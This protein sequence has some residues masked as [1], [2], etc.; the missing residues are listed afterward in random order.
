MS[1]RNTCLA[2][3]FALLV[4]ATMPLLARQ[5]AATAGT[6]TTVV[7]TLEPRRESTI[8]PISQGDLTVVEAGQTRPVTG[9]ESLVNAPTQMLI[10]IDDSARSSFNSLIPQVKQFIMALSPETQVAVGYMDN[11]TTELTS[12]FTTDHS[13]AAASVRVVRGPGG[14]DVSPYDSLEDAIKNWPK[15]KAPRREVVMISSGVE[16]LGGGFMENNPYVEAGIDAAQKAGLVAY[17]IYNPSVGH[18]GHSYFRNVWGQNFLAELSDRTGGEFYNQIMGPVV[19]MTP[20]LDKILQE[21]KHQFALTFL[22]KPEEKSGLQPLKI[23]INRKDASIAYPGRVYVK[24][25]L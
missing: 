18:F 13:A 20:F 1:I 24:A 6:P 16:G 25:S 9:F 22:A 15:D 8:P 10:M 2:V 4:V 14:A 23:T 21:Q 12:K 19:N 3:S 5:N 11:G 7:V 17:T